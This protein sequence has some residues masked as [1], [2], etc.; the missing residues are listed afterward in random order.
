MS[1]RTW[2]GRLA[3]TLILVVVPSLA[4]VLA[5]DVTLLGVFPDRALVG[6]D[7]QRVVLVAG[8]EGQQDVRLLS[9]DTLERRAWLRIDGQRRELTVMGRAAGRSGDAA[10]GATRV[11][12]DGTG[13]FSVS[14][15]IGGHAVRFR[16]DPDAAATLL[17]AAEAE[18]V[19]VTTGQGRLITV[20]TERGR[21]FGHRVILPPVRI[22]GIALDRVE[23]V[24]LQG[25]APRLPVLGMSFLERVQVREDQGTLLLRA[26]GR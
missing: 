19:G 23:A 26:P 9:T 18:R 6:I 8:Q 5:R 20:Q 22:G 15:S 13:A 12:R 25:D 3:W 2:R 16:V 1:A 10:A 21:A 7:G 17:N 24:I 14:G 4:P 11:H